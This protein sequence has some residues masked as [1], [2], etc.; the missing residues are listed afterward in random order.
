MSHKVRDCPR[1][2]QNVNE[3]ATLVGFAPMARSVTASGI[4]S[5][6]RVTALVLENTQNTRTIVSGP[7]GDF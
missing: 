3:P 1:I 5:Q 6:G 2:E 7:H 4:A